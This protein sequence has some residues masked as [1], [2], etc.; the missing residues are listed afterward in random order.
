MDTYESR[1]Y[2]TVENF[3][4]AEVQHG[5]YQRNALIN[6]D[7]D[8]SG[9]IQYIDGALPEGEFKGPDAVEQALAAYRRKFNIPPPGYHPRLHVK[10]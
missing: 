2:E 9:V 3:R 10:G 6:P 4:I 8:H 7:I 5:R 1:R